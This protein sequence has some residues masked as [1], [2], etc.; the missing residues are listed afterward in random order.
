[1]VRAYYK[2]DLAEHKKLNAFHLLVARGFHTFLFPAFFLAVAACF[3]AV[4]IVTGTSVFFAAAAVLAAAAAVLPFLNLYMQNVKTEKNIRAKPDYL[5]TEQFFLFSGSGF[6]LT[7]RVNGHSEDY[8]VPYDQVLRVYE[9]KE[10]FYIYIGGSKVLIV[11]KS[12][13]EENGTDALAAYFRCMGKRF[14]EKKKLR[15]A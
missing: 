12:D 6:R 15:G 9:R 10:F 5:K 14:K 1:M 3:L 7:I 11:K 8:D 2:N 4:G 13:I